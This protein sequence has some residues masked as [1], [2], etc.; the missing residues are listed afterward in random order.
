[1]DA[2]VEAPA[3]V[4]AIAVA[5]PAMAV[6][7]RVGMPV[8]PVGVI[9]AAP[10]DCWNGLRAALI[11]RPA[12][13]NIS[14]PVIIVRATTNPMPKRAFQISPLRRWAGGLG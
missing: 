6:G 12:T 1:M 9:R 5:A 11:P 14:A 7:V 3:T 13:R 2:G 8:D 10:P 4:V